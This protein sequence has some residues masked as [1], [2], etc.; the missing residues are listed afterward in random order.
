MNQL[1]KFLLADEKIV[2]GLTAC[3]NELKNNMANETAADKA[4]RLGLHKKIMEMKKANAVLVNHCTND[5]PLPEV[6]IEKIIR[7]HT[8][9]E[10]VPVA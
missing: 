9:V 8:A 10:K 7:A 2:A 3:Y 4:T 5:R 6:E 1:I